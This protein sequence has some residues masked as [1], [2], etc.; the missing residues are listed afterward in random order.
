MFFYDSKKVLST[1]PARLLLIILSSSLLLSLPAHANT[2]TD[3][4][5]KLA[6]RVHTRVGQIWN[7]GNNELYLTHFAW[8][9]RAYYSAAEVR[10]YRELSW[11][12]GWGKGLY[13]EDGD[14][15][16]LFGIAFLDSHSRVEPTAGYGYQKIIRIGT[17]GRL[18]IGYTAFMTARHNMNYLP[19]PVV[20]PL[21]SIGYGKATA[22]ASYL[23][24]WNGNGNVLFIF[25]TW[26]F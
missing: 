2:A 13:D 18:G 16:G 8:H 24:G 10:R 19:V 9:N 3:K 15:Q 12:G 11:G 17:Q 20:L 7:Q 23:P 4:I 21:A 26:R 14:W 6:Q 5:S 22:Y 1:R 25:S